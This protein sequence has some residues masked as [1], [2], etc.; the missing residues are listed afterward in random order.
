MVDGT[1]KVGERDPESTSWSLRGLRFHERRCRP[2]PG[3]SHSPTGLTLTMNA[4]ITRGLRS[5]PTIRLECYCPSR[6]IRMIRLEQHHL[7]LFGFP[8]SAGVFHRVVPPLLS[9]SDVPCSLNLQNTTQV[10]KFLIIR[11][12][13]HGAALPSLRNDE[14]R[15]HFPRKTTYFP[16]DVFSSRQPRHRQRWS[17]E[18]V[19]FPFDRFPDTQHT[20]HAVLDKS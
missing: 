17:R 1:P 15:I 9:F 12:G 11:F 13:N 10:H 3:V 7:I 2:A 5:E 19:S 14:G 20:Q 6:D 16:K 8:V 4:T 18:T